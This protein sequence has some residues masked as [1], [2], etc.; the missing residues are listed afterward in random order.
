MALDLATTTG[1]C[2]GP[3]D[4]LPQVGHVKLP[5]T[6]DEVGPYLDAFERWFAEKVQLVMPD[7]VVFEAPFHRRFD[8]AV[9][10]RKLHAL[11]GVAEMVC[12]RRRIDVRQV[13]PKAAKKTLTG[14]GAADKNLMMAW[15]RAY[16][17]TIRVSDEADAFA[18]WLHAFRFRE[19][20]QAK[21]FDAAF[22]RS[23]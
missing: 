4:T 22:R 12:F 15:A 3:G 1:F 19:P 23:P 20:D 17:L 2:Y 18:L 9:V 14:S 5:V 21:R 10:T 16:G 11:P 6:Y 8:R 13:A 7:L